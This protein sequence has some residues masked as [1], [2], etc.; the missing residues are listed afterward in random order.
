MSKSKIETI[1]QVQLMTNSQRQY[2]NLINSIG[3]ILWEAEAET[4]KFTFISKQAEKLFGYP[5][6]N[7]LTQANFWE[8]HIYQ[9]DRELAVEY[10]MTSI[11]RKQDYAF[12]YRFITKTNEIIW[13]RNI[14][15]LMIENGVITKLC[16]AIIDITE[17]KI[18][19]E[20]ITMFQKFMNA[21]SEGMRMATLDKKIVYANAALSNFVNNNN[22]LH[23]SFIDYY[24]KKLQQRLQQEV[25]PKLMQNQKWTGEM[26]LVSK[27]G[28]I[29]D[30]R[31]NFF[32]IKDEIGTPQYIAVITSNITEQ[33]KSQQILKKL[34]K[35][36][37]A[38]TECRQILIHAKDED[39][40]LHEICQVLVHDIGY[41]LVWIGFAQQDEN[42]TVI[43]IS[44]CGYEKDY[45]RDIKISWGDNKWGQNPTGI[46]IRTGKPSVAQ[47]I[48]TDPKYNI[49]RSEAMQ[50]GYVSSMAVPLQ[51]GNKII[52]AMTIY[53]KKINAFGFD[54]VA[55]FEE[56]AADLTYGIK[57]LR[58]H[59][60][61]KNAKKALQVSEKRFRSLFES[62]P[63]A[64]FITDAKTFIVVDANIAAAELLLKSRKN[65]IGMNQAQLFSTKNHYIQD[66]LMQYAQKET[67]LVEDLVQRSDGTT[68][69]VEI[70]SS[71]T[72]INGNLMI[73]S[74]FRDITERKQAETSLRQAKESAE[75]ANQAKSEFLANMSHEIR[76]PMNAILGFS[77]LLASK[78]EDKKY[79]N[80]LNSIQIAGKTLLTLIND[81]LDLSKIEAGQLDIQYEPINPITIFN[82]I[83]QIFAL[84]FRDKGLQFIIEIEK[85]LPLALF[86]D[87][88]RLRQILVNL[89]GNAIKFTKTGYVKFCVSKRELANNLIDLIIDVEDTGIGISK[90]QQT[91][92]FESFKQQDGQSTR[93][94]GGT[95]LGLAISKRL[96]EMMSGKIEVRSNLGIGS[97]F[98][99]T[100]YNV[101]IHKSAKIANIQNKNRQQQINF[102]LNNVYF[103]TAVVLVVDDIEVNLRIVKEYLSQVGLEVIFAHNGQEALI[104]AEEYQPNLILM[105]LRMPGMDGYETTQHLK[106]N[107]KTK[108][109]PIIA[110]TASVFI[111]EKYKV[112]EHGFDGFLSKPINL[113]SL[114]EKLADYLTMTQKMEVETSPDIEEISLI[115]LMVATN[116]IKQSPE[117]INILTTTVIPLWKE[118]KVMMEVDMVIKFTDELIKL[119]NNYHIPSFIHYAEQLRE[120]S[121]NFD[122]L[123]TEN[124]LNQFSEIADLITE[125]TQ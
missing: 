106:A 23:E 31:E 42:K 29:I 41:C 65:I 77:D 3:G 57:M 49:L 81:I 45:L 8:Q 117:L 87:E 62:M 4:L 15:T 119:G 14:V 58:I 53:A 114:L 33:K 47:D 50:R 44:Q 75:A 30:T 101:E 85:N 123:N 56:L 24:P 25:F 74:V 10:S 120:F 38:L 16:G 36:F 5:I 20:K 99:V 94:Y 102:N 60:E 98:E 46:S 109:I 112:L 83:Q 103:E 6:T 124:F 1:L 108:N 54:T 37:K 19:Q 78:L 52:G 22:L 7:W 35:A 61:R 121:Q 80:H 43:P 9:E 39:T 34:N 32:L 59:T 11:A 63:D 105:D 110:L 79:Q 66:K 69:P 68:I 73:Q 13:V 18:N 118:T 55:L 111:E 2:K 89:V 12:D 91:I 70:L 21:A 95:G 40:L 92:I 67:M 27:I 71:L 17:Q 72:H 28:Q 26:Q 116:T 76:T 122:I 96:I 97:T 84:K 104:F 90:D 115:G 107:Q 113:S 51:L 100:L 88:T 48:L 125:V 86:L 82:E 64:I 93:K